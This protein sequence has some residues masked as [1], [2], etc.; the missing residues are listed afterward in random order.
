M[1]PPKPMKTLVAVTTPEE[2]VVPS[3]LTISPVVTLAKLGEVTP[4]SLYVVE[5]LTST[6]TVLPSRPFTV[7]VPVPLTDPAVTD[8]TLPAA[9]GGE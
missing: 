2:A 8:S 1:P 3:T 9:A 5:E 4:G 6:V 7:K